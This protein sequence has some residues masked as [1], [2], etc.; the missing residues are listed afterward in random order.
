MIYKRAYLADCLLPP[1]VCRVSKI[2]VESGAYIRSGNI[3]LESMPLSLCFLTIIHGAK[4][5]TEVRCWC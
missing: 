3:I 4:A 1:G 2:P 5:C